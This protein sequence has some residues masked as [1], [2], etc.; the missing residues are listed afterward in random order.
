MTLPTGEYGVLMGKTGCGK[1]TILEAICGL[2]TVTRGRIRLAGRDVTDRKPAARGIG[3]V[4][5]DGALFSTMSVREHLAFSLTIRHWK[6]EAI[7]ERV[8]ELAELLGIAGLLDRTPEGLSG[9]EAQRVALGRA[10]ANRPE[11]LCLDEPLSA[12]DDE[13]RLDMIELLRS[14]QT[15]TGV[16]TLHITHNWDEVKDLA[17]RVYRIQDGQLRELSVAET[18]R[19]FRRGR[20]EAL[21]REMA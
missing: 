19:T 14:L 16:T 21:C 6:A 20:E 12:L 10:L 1:T 8:G 11:I 7:E 13:T 17:D 18:E 4:P 3:L 9:G 15:Y 2:K 5:Q